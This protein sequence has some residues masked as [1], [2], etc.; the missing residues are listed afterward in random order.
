MSGDVHAGFALS[1][2]DNSTPATAA[3]SDFTV[4]SFVE[5]HNENC[6]RGQVDGLFDPSADIS[7]LP[8]DSL[9]A[10]EFSH[11]YDTFYELLIDK[12][13]T[14]GS[15]AILKEG[16]I[17]ASTAVG[18]RSKKLETPMQRSD[19]FKLASVDKMVTKQVIVILIND[20]NLAAHGLDLDMDTNVLQFL[21]INLNLGLTPYPHP[22]RRAPHQFNDDAETIKIEHL[23][24]HRSYVSSPPE[25]L[26]VM[27]ALYF[28]YGITSREWQ[29]KHLAQWL[30]SEQLMK[31]AA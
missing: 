6:K 2:L 27:E 25:V 21:N 10:P 31:M 17:V 29:A 8:Q 1:S 5:P 20:P 19:I 14:G 13:A 16:K 24:Y 23:L 3:I 11:I 22:D 30:F 26:A 15:M 18:Y 28:A 7:V 12:G 4:D 9:D